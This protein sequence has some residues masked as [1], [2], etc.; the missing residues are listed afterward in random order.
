MSRK[1]YPKILDIL[2]LVNGNKN[3]GKQYAAHLLTTDFDRIRFYDFCFF[4][5]LIHSVTAGIE[6]FTLL[7]ISEAVI[8]LFSF[9]AF[10][11]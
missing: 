9:N 6:R 10:Q 7:L 1:C 11:N 5:F 3:E 4:Q 8:L 2:G